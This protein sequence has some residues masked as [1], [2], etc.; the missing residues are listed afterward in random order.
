MGK[1][2][3]KRFSRIVGVLWL[4]SSLY[5]LV[6]YG[7][8]WTVIFY[9]DGDNSLS[10]SASYLLQTISHFGRNQRVKIV[11]LI[12]Y[13][14]AP[15]EIYEIVR[16]ERELKATLPEKDLAD[17]NFFKEFIIFCRDN[18]PAKRYSLIFYDH[19]NGWYPELSPLLRRAILYDA[20]SNNSVG[21]AGG[22]LKRFIS[23]AKE[24]LRKEI[25]II[26][27]DVC[28]GGMVEVL[29]EVKDYANFCLASPSLIPVDAWDYEGLLD[30]LEKNPEMSGRELGKIWVELN[31]RK[32]RGGVYSAYDLKALREIKIKRIVTDLSKKDRGIL[33]EKRRQCQTYPL[34]EREPD[35]A[36]DNIDILHF[37]KLLGTE[38][39]LGKVLLSF[40]AD[41]NY[42][43]SYG[44]ATWFPS[45]Y[46]EFKKWYGAYLALEFNKEADWV[47]FLYRYYGRD[48][49]KPT[50]VRLSST[51]VGK[52]NDFTVSWSV[53]FDLAEVSYQLYSYS[54]LETLLFDPGDT[55]SFWE[56]DFTLSRRAHSPPNSFFSGRGANLNKSLTL[57]EP[58]SLREGGILYFWTFY[59]TEEIYSDTLIK[60]DI[61]YIE[62]S[63]NKVDWAGIDSIYGEN[64]TWRL[65]SY[66]LPPAE[67]L[68][69]R[70]RYLTDSSFNL[71]GVFID[72]ITVLSLS[73]LKRYGR[74]IK[75]TTFYI[76]NLP[77]GRYNF[78]VIPIDSVGNKGFVSNFISSEINTPCR[79]FSFPSPFF[80]S[81]KIFLDVEDNTKGRLYII[82]IAGRIVR[83][84]KFSGSE[85]LF[86][87]RDKFGNLLPLGNYFIRIDQKSLLRGGKICKVR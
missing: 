57:K 66:L 24:I 53:S 56:G 38:S 18:Y 22:E 76:F 27:F 74:E 19:G 43:N 61:F 41:T 75:D 49:I 73:K 7:V 67:S 33:L 77:K 29:Y 50:M 14:E 37:L 59:E 52:E 3:K 55:F 64:L 16:G 23:T 69:I 81:T 58:L 78:F 62:T 26:G 20:S 32:G 65:H 4:I 10:G 34:I 12:D 51:P 70:F 21:V 84:L 9:L 36:D 2:H 31:R 54:L 35:P 60:R 13:L 44:L 6:G 42:E 39:D 79:P 47:S 68:W 1:R 15:P 86:D 46:G 28:L 83:G 30:T 80:N 25:E 45:N 63:H 85:I 11:C 87:G 72:D 40:T 5:Y 82:D 48:D 17:I 71:L 8:E